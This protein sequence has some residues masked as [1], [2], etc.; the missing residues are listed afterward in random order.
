MIIAEQNKI[1]GIDVD[2]VLRNFCDSL[3]S[4]V[5]MYYPEYLKAGVTEITDWQLENNFNC[6]KKDLQQIYWQ[7]RYK[8]VIKD[9]VD[10]LSEEMRNENGGFYSAVDADSENEEGKFYV[11]NIDEIKEVLGK[12]YKIAKNLYKINEEGN[13]EGKIILLKDLK[14]KISSKKIKS[15]KSSLLKHRNK[16]NKPFIDKKIISSWNGIILIGLLNCYQST[17]VKKY[18]DLAKSNAIFIKEKLIIKNKIKRI[19]DSNINGFL[20]DYAIIINA[21]IKYYETTQDFTF[22]NISRN[23]MEYTI[24]HFY[25]KKDKMFFYSGSYNEKLL[26]KKIQIFDDVIPSSNSIMH[27]NLLYLGKIYNDSLYNNIYNYMSQK[28]KKY[29]TNYE[30]MA[31]WIYVNEL[32]KSKINEIVVNDSEY[33]ESIIQEINSWYLPNKILV[34]NNKNL[35]L[36]ILNSHKVSKKLSFSLCRNNVC[37]E[38]YNSTNKLKKAIYK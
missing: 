34:Y 8:E 17:K 7:D 31:N 13:W 3:M 27:Y 35:K 32:N 21:F 28:L 30:F 2:G 36:E 33:D 4:V 16:R 25:S 22:L 12:D 1:I 23:L 6:S 24:K 14:N 18:L 20:D 37:G 38:P 15:L 9:T 19:Y 5:T 29:L 10:W 26:T 11:W